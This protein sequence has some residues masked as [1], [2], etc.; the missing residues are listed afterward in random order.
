VLR[1]FKNL[2]IVVLIIQPKIIY[3]D[4]LSFF[5]DVNPYRGT[6]S[7]IENVVSSSS[8]YTNNDDNFNQNKIEINSEK[9]NENNSNEKFE[10]RNK[11]CSN[12]NSYNSISP[13]L[14]FQERFWIKQGSKGVYDRCG[15]KNNQKIL[16][17]ATLL[18]KIIKDNDE[19]NHKFIKKYPKISF[20][21]ISENKQNKNKR[22]YESLLN[23]I[24]NLREDLYLETNGMIIQRYLYENLNLKLK[25]KKQILTDEEQDF[26]INYINE[27]YTIENIEN[28]SSIPKYKEIQNSNNHKIIKKIKFLEEI[29]PL[30]FYYLQ[31]QKRKLK[32]NKVNIKNNKKPFVHDLSILFNS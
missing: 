22:Y 4:N 31:K 23:E 5:V 6:V 12:I 32:K 14:S 16:E 19:L 7:T 21:E 1:V 15:K 11:Y 3:A 20:L 29:N 9:R 24:D 26:Y 30:L 18:N 10:I 27:I 28:F 2:L 25:S 17:R 8:V 13:K